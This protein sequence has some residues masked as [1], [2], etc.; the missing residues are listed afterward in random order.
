MSYGFYKTNKYGAR[1]ITYLGMT[2]DSKK[3]YLRYI[4]LSCLEKAKKIACLQ[5]QVKYVLIPSQRDE[6]GKVIEREVSY[7]ADF[8]YFD[9]EQGK[10]IVEDVKGM[11][12][13][14]YILKRKMMLYFNGIRIKEV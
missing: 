4:E 12:T 11:K 5:R 2:F 8:V 1:K 3:E 9:F 10:L 7:I 13:K 6:K 14:D